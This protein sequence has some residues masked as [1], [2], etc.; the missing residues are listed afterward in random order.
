MY[1]KI[2]NKIKKLSMN[3]YTGINHHKNVI[4]KLTKIKC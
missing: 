4:S 2:L 3:I 1:N